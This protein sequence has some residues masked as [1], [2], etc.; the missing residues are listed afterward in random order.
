MN[1]DGKEATCNPANGHPEPLENDFYSTLLVGVSTTSH[2]HGLSYHMQCASNK[3]T[4]IHIY[5]Q[6]PG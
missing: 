6:K 2:Q 4:T 5:I 3:Q 1:E